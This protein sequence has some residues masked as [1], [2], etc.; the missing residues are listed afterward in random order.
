MNEDRAGAKRHD[1]RGHSRVYTHSVASSWTTRKAVDARPSAPWACRRGRRPAAGAR[2]SLYKWLVAFIAAVVP[3]LRLDLV[4]AAG[5]R[6]LGRCRR[7]LSATTLGERL[8]TV[9]HQP[10]PQSITPQLGRYSDGTPAV[11]IGQRVV[12]EPRPGAQRTGTVT[13]ENRNEMNPCTMPAD[14]GTLPPIPSIPP[15]IP[16]PLDH[17]RPRPTQTSAGLLSRYSTTM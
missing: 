4:R 11:A 14:G 5:R 2:C 15:T 1:S 16:L 8:R 6:L 10:T 9:D 12:V 7:R 3:A 17:S 13:G